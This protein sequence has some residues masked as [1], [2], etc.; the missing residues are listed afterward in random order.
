MRK[1][2]KFCN[3]VKSIKDFNKKNKSPDGFATCCRDCYTNLQPLWAEDNLKK[4]D[5]VD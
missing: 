5:K 2:C 1:N 4:S 3:T